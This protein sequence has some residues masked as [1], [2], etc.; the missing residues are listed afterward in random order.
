MDL[1]EVLVVCVS[2]NDAELVG[3]QEADVG[4]F[5]SN[6]FFFFFLIVL[7]RSFYWILRIFNATYL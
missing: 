1:C 5:L 3:V 7:Q 6:V 2:V 4:R